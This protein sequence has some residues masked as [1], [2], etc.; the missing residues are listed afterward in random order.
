MSNVATFP[1]EETQRGEHAGRFTQPRELPRRRSRE[2]AHLE[3][4][5][6]LLAE[7]IEPE[8]CPEFINAFPNL[9]ESTEGHDILTGERVRYQATMRRLA[10]ARLQ[11]SVV[12]GS[13]PDQIAGLKK[14]AAQNAFYTLL[15]KS[16]RLGDFERDYQLMIESVVEARNTIETL[17]GEYFSKQ[18]RHEVEMRLEVVSE[19]DPFELFRLCGHSGNDM[20]SRRIRFEAARQLTLAQ[21]Y[22]E[23]RRHGDSIQELDRDMSDLERELKASY[24]EPRR[25]ATFEV[26]AEL[27]PDDVYRVKHLGWLPDPAQ[28]HQSNETC[29]YLYP[30]MRFIPGEI[31]V[32]QLARVKENAPLKLVSKDRRNPKSVNDLCGLK[33]IFFNLE[34]LQRGIEHLRRSIVVV[35]GTVYGQASNLSRSGAVD[36]TNRNS[37]EDARFTKYSALLFDRWFEI[38]FEL[39]TDWVNEQFSMGREN[40][41]MY[42]LR[43]LLQVILPKLFPTRLYL[44]WADPNIRKSLIRFRLAEIW[45]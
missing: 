28:R 11:A 5:L 21:L 32:L 36:P 38:Q 43:L 3:S 23:L 41:E 27:D 35:P 4:I 25:S 10:K 14:K 30:G 8:T 13:S 18:L 22:F 20:A 45:S 17:V 33:L 16:Y 26:K 31:P 1:L 34:D 42:K 12:P 7:P 37:S 6:S 40:H 29:V 19:E 9:I 15:K 2:E 39:M 44:D 24:F